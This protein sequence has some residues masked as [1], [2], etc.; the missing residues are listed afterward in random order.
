M[1]KK[2]VE[3]KHVLG[4][5][6]YVVIVFKS[7]GVRWNRNKMSLFFCEAKN[8]EGIRDCWKKH[9]PVSSGHF[10]VCDSVVID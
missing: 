10:S 9:V 5:M 8:Y 4:V 6:D 3:F 1:R 2:K 7:S